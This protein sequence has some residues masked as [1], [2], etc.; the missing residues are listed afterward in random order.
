MWL[1]LTCCSGPLR[2]AWAIRPGELQR[3]ISDLP[4]SRT[5]VQLG[6]LSYKY[7]AIARATNVVGIC[8]SFVNIVYDLGIGYI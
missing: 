4:G 2:L 8:K 5:T 3:C 1:H 7:E 6:Q